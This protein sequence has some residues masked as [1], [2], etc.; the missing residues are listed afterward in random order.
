MSELVLREAP[1]S[2]GNNFQVLDEARRI[3]G[4]IVLLTALAGTHAKPWM[5]SID[6]ASMKAAIKPTASRRRARPPWRRSPGAG[7]GRCDGREL[8]PAT[9]AKWKFVLGHL[10]P[11][12]GEHEPVSFLTLRGAVLGLF[13]AGIGSGVELFSF[14]SRRGHVRVIIPISPPSIAKFGEFQLFQEPRYF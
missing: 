11:V 4:Y 13:N 7:T 8:G 1:G 2:R 5:W 9:S 10:Q 14:R 6:S 12:L 3:I